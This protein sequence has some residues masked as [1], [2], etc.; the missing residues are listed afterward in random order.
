MMTTDFDWHLLIGDATALPA[1]S[2]RLAEFPA[3]TK[4]VVLV[5]V[6][7]PEDEIELTS[8]AQLSVTWVHRNPAEGGAATTL[9]DALKALAKAELLTGDFYAWIACESLTA[10]ALRAQLIAEQGAHPKWIKAAGYWK[11]GNVA[12]HDKHED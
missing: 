4:A 7:T 12:V 1:I 2:R 11:E 10:K 3:S 6:E 8:A 5:E 9:A